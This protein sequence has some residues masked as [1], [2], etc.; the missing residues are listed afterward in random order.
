MGSKYLKIG[1]AMGGA[2]LIIFVIPGFVKM[3]PHIPTK[4]EIEK[5][6]ELIKTSAGNT[7]TNIKNSIAKNIS[8]PYQTSVQIVSEKVTPTIKQENYW[9]PTFT[10]TPQRVPTDFNRP[11]GGLI[12][13]ETP[14]KV[15]SPTVRP[16]LYIKPSIIPTKY[17]PPPTSTSIPTPTLR[18]TIYI[19]PPTSTPIPTPTEVVR[20][21]NYSQI[22][23]MPS[24]PPVIGCRGGTT[25]GCP[26]D[27]LYYTALDRGLGWATYYGEEQYIVAEVI[28]N[29]KGISMSDARSFVNETYMTKQSHL[30]PEEA[31]ST[32]KVI[33]Y[34]ATRG[35]R[36]LWSIKYLFGIDN[37]SNPQP[38]FIGRVM[39]IDMAA[40]QDWSGNL[41]KLTYSY[42]GWKGLNW[43]VDLSKNGF[44][45][46]PS[47]YSGQQDN[48][49]EG[50][51]GVVLIDESVIDQY[52]YQ[53]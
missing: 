44:V 9:A 39:I 47:G 14:V 38:R 26:V 50:R 43:I 45:Q 8:F 18:P 4:E 5:Y 46:I 7:F 15:L 10:P 28:H 24:N 51:P 2:F 49:R 35:P 12:L 11:L 17:I 30:T 34:G 41:A 27:Q 21:P 40:P 36:D 32:G 6:T 42:K 3:R 22:Q 1:I 20:T 33:A 16:T 52:I 25:S 37:P 13:T 53:Q 29:R 48:V 31:R 23:S 19:P